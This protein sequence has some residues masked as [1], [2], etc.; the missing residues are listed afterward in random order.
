MSTKTAT[1]KAPTP[2]A[3]KA[4]ITFASI[5]DH[6]SAIDVN[7]HV[8]KKQGL[9]YLSWAWAWGVMMDNYPDMT[10]SW[11]GTPPTHDTPGYDDVVYYPGGSAKVECTVDIAG[12]KRSV[13][14]PVMDHRMKAIPNPD[15]RQISDAKMRCL[16][17]CFALFGLG[18]YIYAGEDVPPDNDE[19]DVVE[20]KIRELKAAGRATFNLTAPLAQQAREAIEARDVAKMDAAMA[21]L[22]AHQKKTQGAD[23]SDNSNQKDS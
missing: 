8:K 14:L 9:S 2:E 6:L 18:H 20:T 19:Q 17:K 3:E 11:T 16:V 10:V 4:P 7:Q 5:W 23:N 12:Y 22:R 15:S 1:A 21:A 13:W